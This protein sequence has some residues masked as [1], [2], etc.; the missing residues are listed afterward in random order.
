MGP[1]AFR[2]VIN[3]PALCARLCLVFLLIAAP[4]SSAPASSAPV[5]ITASDC[6]KAPA[7]PLPLPSSLKQPAYQNFDVTLYDF[8]NC[9]NYLKLDWAHDKGVRNTGPYVSGSAY[10]THPAVRIF[11]SPQIIARLR[12]GKKAAFPMAQ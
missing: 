5:K 9:G 3:Y 10:G 4:A 11:Y 12:N 7:Y 1:I 8:L 6:S 2:G